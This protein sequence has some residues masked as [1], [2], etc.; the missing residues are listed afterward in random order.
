M[1]VAKLCRRSRGD[2]GADALVVLGG[3]CGFAHRERPEPAT[4]GAFETGR[5]RH[6][7]AVAGPPG[8]SRMGVSIQFEAKKTKMDLLDGTPTLGSLAAETIG[9]ASSM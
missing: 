9:H 2:F 1:W 6:S 3:E 5:A 8:A 4:D 7:K